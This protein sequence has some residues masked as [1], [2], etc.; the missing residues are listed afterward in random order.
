LPM[1]DSFWKKHKKSAE[2]HWT[3]R[4]SALRQKGV[5]RLRT[6]I[7][8]LSPNLPTSPLSP[9]PLIHSLFTYDSSPHFLISSIL[10]HKR[11][12]FIN[13]TFHNPA[14]RL[15][16]RLEAS[17]GQGHVERDQTIKGFPAAEG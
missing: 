12:I 1:T 17:A 7:L 5:A 15:D 14:S 10:R 9:P 2:C 4:R 3:L 11:N 6:R 13:I 8:L 16:Y